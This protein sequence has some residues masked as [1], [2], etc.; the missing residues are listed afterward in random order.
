M[1]YIGSRDGGFG[2]EKLTRE[3]QERPIRTVVPVKEG[4][5]GVP[6]CSPTLRST[7]DVVRASDFN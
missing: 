3:T 4:H 2:S 5:S 6:C 1:L 7:S